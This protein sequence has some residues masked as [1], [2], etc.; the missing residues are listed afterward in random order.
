MHIFLSN[1]CYHLFCFYFSGTLTAICT[2]NNIRY[3]YDLKSKHSNMTKT[4]IIR[5][6]T[7][8]TEDFGNVKWYQVKKYGNERKIDFFV[9][10]E[11]FRFVFYLWFVVIIIAGLVLTHGFAVNYTKDYKE[12]VFKV[13]GSINFC[14]LFDFP[15]STYVLPSLYAIHVVIIFQYSIF[16]VFRAWIAKLEC[17][18]SNYSFICYTSVF[19]YYT[20]S[21][22]IFSTVFAVRPDLNPKNTKQ[23]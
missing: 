9:V 16:S 23:L 4:R 1:H 5:N 20:I 8:N 12:I 13:F 22:A 2:L 14:A 19:I 7:S 11:F 17:K 18:I 15:P 21:A 3:F 10:V 6:G